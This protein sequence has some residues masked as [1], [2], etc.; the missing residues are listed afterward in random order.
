MS[1]QIQGSVV[2]VDNVN[3]FKIFPALADSEVIT[4]DTRR[5]IF[6]RVLEFAEYYDSLETKFQKLMDQPEILSGQTLRGKNQR[7][8]NAWCNKFLDKFVNS[9]D[10]IDF[11]NTAEYLENEILNNLAAILLAK[12]IKKLDPDEFRKKYN[13]QNDLTQEQI[14]QL[15]SEEAIY[16]ASKK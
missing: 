12:E 8:V 14:Q 2:N 6:D 9:N 3:V 7:S 4:I 11:I 15:D 10:I 13:I 5:F 1:V 16:K